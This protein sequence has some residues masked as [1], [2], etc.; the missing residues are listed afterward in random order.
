MQYLVKRNGIHHF[1]IAIPLYLKP[2]FGKKTEYT[3]STRTKHFTLAMNHARI[4]SRIFNMIK[5]AAK[6]NLGSKFIEHL[7]FTL[8]EAKEIKKCQRA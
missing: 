8:L 2:Y 7:V 4:Y 1:R 5:K 6:M 3:N